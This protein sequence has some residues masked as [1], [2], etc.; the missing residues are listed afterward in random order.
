MLALV[1]PA[2][3][4]IQ[5]LA[6]LH[7]GQTAMSYMPVFEIL[8]VN[9]FLAGLFLQSV[10]GFAGLSFRKNGLL[11]GLIICLPIIC[12]IVVVKHLFNIEVIGMF[13]FNGILLGL[14]LLGWVS[15]HY[16]LKKREI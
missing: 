13:V 7:A 14:T 6:N 8:T 11:Y 4:F 15:I 2:T 16:K 5:A 12:T 9:N 3:I 10:Y 1:V